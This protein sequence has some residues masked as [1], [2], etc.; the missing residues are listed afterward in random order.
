MV[1]CKD[2]FIRVLPLEQNK[3]S[4]RVISP[5]KV[6]KRNPLP[7]GISCLGE[8]KKKTLLFPLISPLNNFF[9]GAIVC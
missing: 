5:L 9:K 8:K 1:K 7:W 2:L 3:A 6:R 4:A